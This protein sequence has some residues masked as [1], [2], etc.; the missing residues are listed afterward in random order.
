M[1]Q[2][3]VTKYLGPTNARGSRVKASAEAGSLT[4]SWNDSLNSDQNH[5]RAAQAL[6]KRFGWHGNWYGGAIPGIAYAWVLASNAVDGRD[7]F[8]VTR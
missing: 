6:A 8:S 3:I 1:Y 7:C 4:L 5:A 2:A